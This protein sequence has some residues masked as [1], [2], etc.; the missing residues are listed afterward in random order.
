MKKIF[1]ILA[2]AAFICLAATSCS[3][4]SPAGSGTATYSFGAASMHDDGE[5]FLKISEIYL[6]H[7]NSIAGAQVAGSRFTIEGKFSESDSKVL[8]ACKA[9]ESEASQVK[10]E[11]LKYA[12]YH[13][14]ASYIGTDKVND[15]FYDK[16]YGKKQ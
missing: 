3:K 12:T 10:L 2:V 5:I 4:D 1:S 13:V 8:D 14:R 11:G 16:T 7:F 9:A 15:N 6:K